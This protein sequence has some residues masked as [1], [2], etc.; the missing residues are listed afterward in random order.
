MK[1]K[2]SGK[3]SLPKYPSRRQFVESGAL[4]GLATLGLTAMT[5]LGNPAT[6]ET[7]LPG[8]IAVT[9]SASRIVGMIKAEP[10][11][12]NR[13]D[14]ITYTVKPGDTLSGLAKQYL[15]SADR[16]QEIVAINPG[17]TAETLK[18]DR[19]IMIPK[20]SSSAPESNK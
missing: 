4:A 16:W 1:V 6:N 2:K 19:V 10:V 18:S 8:D 5:G 20:K 7:R 9:P 3:P 17:L 13:L 12:T 15:G 14:R 11:T